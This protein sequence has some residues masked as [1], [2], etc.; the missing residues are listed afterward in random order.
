MVADRRYSAYPTRYES[1][2]R[3]ALELL[4]A[5]GSFAC[6]A[7]EGAGGASGAGRPSGCGATGGGAASGTAADVCGMAR[8]TD[9]GAAVPAERA[10]VVPRM[11]IL[12]VIGAEG[13]DGRFDD[14]PTG[15][16]RDTAPPPRP[17]SHSAG[18]RSA[19]S[20]SSGRR[21][22]RPCLRPEVRYRR[23]T[24]ADR[25]RPSSRRR[26]EPPARWEAPRSRAEGGED[27]I[28]RR[29]RRTGPGGPGRCREWR[30]TAQCPPHPDRRP[31][32]HRQ[33]HTRL[34]RY[35]SKPGPR[36]VP[37]DQ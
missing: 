19:G 13:T 37:H 2:I 5:S 32:P 31:S 10:D 24:P 11:T 34:P 21:Q 20:H 17:G 28:C 22:R 15:L 8:G 1:G 30:A 35:E 29:R 26:C 16:T 36:F 3:A 23:S 9:R 18:L 33:T 12:R 7:C 27:R 25:H 4:G 6:G 14:R